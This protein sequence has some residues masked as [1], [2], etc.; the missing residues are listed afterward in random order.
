ML[1]DSEDAVIC[2]WCGQA[3][4]EGEARP[5]FFAIAFHVRCWDASVEAL[6]VPRRRE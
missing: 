5:R 4:Q 1:D 2:E 6:M 3:I